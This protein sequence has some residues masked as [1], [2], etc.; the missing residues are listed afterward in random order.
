MKI[1][2]KI[3]NDYES[4]FGVPRQAGLVEGENSLIIFEP[5]FRVAEALIGELQLFMA[6]MGIQRIQR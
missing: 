4:K 6:Y 5:E 1:I 3:Y 2:A